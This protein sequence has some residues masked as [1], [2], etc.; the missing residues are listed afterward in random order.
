MT[1]A[2][3]TKLITEEEKNAIRLVKRIAVA[4]VLSAPST[5]LRRRHCDW[6]GSGK[7]PAPNRTRKGVYTESACDGGNSR[8]GLNVS[9]FFRSLLPSPPPPLSPYA[10]QPAT[11]RPRPLILDYITFHP[12]AP[13]RVIGVQITFS[14]WC[15]VAYC[16]AM[17]CIASSG[18]WSKRT[19]VGVIVAP[20]PPRA[21][22]AP[23]GSTHET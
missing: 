8:L 14:R 19:F 12:N 1:S 15:L 2:I 17:A 4:L 10:T 21:Y 22:A 18:I 9:V 20:W 11:F 13:L 16:M 6:Q 7:L 3:N 23:I 5:P